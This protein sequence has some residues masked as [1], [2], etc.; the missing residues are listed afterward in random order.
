MQYKM[1][2]VNLPSV[3]RA[4]RMR[5]HLP[6]PN[7]SGDVWAPRFFP[8]LMFSLLDL[9]EG[10]ASHS[11]RLSMPIMTSSGTTLPQASSSSSASDSSPALASWDS[12]I[13]LLGLGIAWPRPL[14]L[15]PHLGLAPN[16]VRP[17]E[18]PFLAHSLLASASRSWLSRWMCM[19]FKVWILKTLDFPGTLCQSPV[20]EWPFSVAPNS[21]MCLDRM[22]SHMRPRM[23]WSPSWA[24]NFKG[25]DGVS[26]GDCCRASTS[27]MSC[28]RSWSG[29]DT[30]S[31]LGE[32]GAWW[33]EVGVLSL[34]EM[35]LWNTSVF[36]CR[37]TDC[38]PHPC[39]WRY[40]RIK[41]KLSGLNGQI[42]VCSKPRTMLVCVKAFL[43]A[44]GKS[45]NDLLDNISTA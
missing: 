18:C 35:G 16:L 44:C 24:N 22:A 9:L 7:C 40:F 12:D 39:S 25:R 29:V 2:Y 19:S 1:F 15:A 3:N 38:C 31:N 36:D 14:P 13:L 10:S 33:C 27:E 30:I 17:L 8:Y 26:G 45:L 37:D 28:W 32:V 5:F 20:F 21:R 11:G 6:S 43:W 23:T 42:P 41:S 34:D 4:G